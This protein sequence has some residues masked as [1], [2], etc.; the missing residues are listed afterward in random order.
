MVLSPILSERIILAAYQYLDH[1]FDYETFN[2]IHFVIKVYRDAGIELP[3]LVRGDYP[4]PDFHLAPDKFAVMPIG[5]SVFLKRKANLFDRVWTHAA[6]IVS[7]DSLIHCSRHF[8]HK[9]A[10]TEKS[11]LLNIYD[12]AVS[13]P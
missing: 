7:S 8:G 1:S 6:I 2:C 9:V 4:P 10:V 12:L 5:H 13:R 11:E 3:L